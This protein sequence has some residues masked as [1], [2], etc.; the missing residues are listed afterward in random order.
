M[1]KMIIVN[2]VIIVNS[3]GIRFMIIKIQDFHHNV[4]RKWRF[5]PAHKKG[6]MDIIN[7]I[8][9]FQKYNHQQRLKIGKKFRTSGYV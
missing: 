2:S 5:L 7:I 6:L 4:E 9:I 1:R 3:M 8:K